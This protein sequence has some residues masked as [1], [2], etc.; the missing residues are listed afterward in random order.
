MVLSYYI[1]MCVFH[2]RQRDMTSVKHNV[3]LVCGI[4]TGCLTEN[5]ENIF[6]NESLRFFR[7]RRRFA[8][9]TSSRLDFLAAGG[10]G[11]AVSPPAGVGAAPRLENA[12]LS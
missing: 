8:R 3:F 7:A 4:K 1:G 10:P 9:I 6:V 12:L 5:R 2:E 11:G